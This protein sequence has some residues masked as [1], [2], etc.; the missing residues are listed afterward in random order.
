VDHQKKIAKV[1]Y[2]SIPNIMLDREAIP[3]FLF[4]NCQA[5]ILAEKLRE[6]LTDR[7][8]RERQRDDMDK[9]LRQLINYNGIDPLVPSEIASDVILSK[10]KEFRTN[11]PTL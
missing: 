7:T 4:N 11:Q 6:L 5:E 8:L 2:A 9:V 10:I 1:K 3:E